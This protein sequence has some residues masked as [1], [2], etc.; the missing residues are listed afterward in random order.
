[1]LYYHTILFVCYNAC[2]NMEA[3]KRNDPKDLIVRL[4]IRGSFAKS[5]NAEE[6]MHNLVEQALIELEETSEDIA[7]IVRQK[8]EAGKTIKEIADEY[9]ETEENIRRMEDEGIRKIRR[10]VKRQKG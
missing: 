10:F 8:Y 9:G 4:D 6:E 5:A 3:P 1:M 2:M 7:T